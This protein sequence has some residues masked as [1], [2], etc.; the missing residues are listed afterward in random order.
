LELRDQP[1]LVAPAMKMLKSEVMLF[2]ARLGFFLDKCV[3]R[4]TGALS[5]SS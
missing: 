2:A 3:L 1:A 5:V 4:G